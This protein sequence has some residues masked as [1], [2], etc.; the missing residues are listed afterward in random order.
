MLKVKVQSVAGRGDQY[1]VTE[2]ISLPYPTPVN[3]NAGSKSPIG[4]EKIPHVP[5][6]CLYSAGRRIKGHGSDHRELL[7]GQAELVLCRKRKQVLV[8][9]WILRLS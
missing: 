4:L 8:G 9:D 7:W 1:R 5:S 6:P 3:T 2:A